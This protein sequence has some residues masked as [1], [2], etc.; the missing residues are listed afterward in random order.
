M[1]PERLGGRAPAK[2]NLYLH[3]APAREDARHDLES[4][5]VFAG[6][7]AADRLAIHRADKT[8]I[9]VTGPMAAGAGPDADNL[10]MR[11]AQM[12]APD[13]QLHFTL[14]KHLPAAA[15]LGGGSADAGAA[16]R[17]VTGL[18]SLDPGEAAR[19]APALGGDVLACL[20]SCPLVMRGDG[21]RVAP[22]T[23]PLA[24]LPALI[25]NPGVACPTGP[26]FQRFDAMGGGA[27]FA[28]LEVPAFEQAERLVEWL[29]SQTRND[30]QAPAISLVPEIGTCLAVL[31]ALPG[32][33]LARMTGS[34]ATCF[35]LFETL[36]R[37]RVAGETLSQAQ[38]DW[39][40]RATLLG[41]G[42]TA[43]S[44]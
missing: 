7:Q 20:H 24:Q 8:G 30:L 42:A 11:A 39:W 6:P 19:V 36:D 1:S 44:M 27:G 29:A 28:P 5:V 17:L 38:P 26:V 35:A 33:R 31:A 4:L 12:L 2:I 16:L 41:E 37:A 43:C 23:S 22:L 40:A 18:L 15:G 14:E 21:D 25:V 32:A 13:T 3:V 34:G 9:E 10:V